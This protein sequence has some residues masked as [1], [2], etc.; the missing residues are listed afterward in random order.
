MV[1]TTLIMTTQ[2]N[3]SMGWPPPIPINCEW[4]RS[5][6]MMNLGA[7]VPMSRTY[8]LVLKYSNYKKYVDPIVHVRVFNVAL[9]ANGKTFE[10]Y[11]SNAFSYTLRKMALD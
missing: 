1:Y 2:A 10:E 3:I 9:R 8:W 4:Q 6:L 7:R 11:I 5:R